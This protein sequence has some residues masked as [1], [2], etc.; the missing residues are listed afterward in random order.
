MRNGAVRDKYFSFLFIVVTCVCLCFALACTGAREDNHFYFV[1]IADTHFGDRDHLER[2]KKVVDQINNLPMK[3]QCVVHTGDITMDMIEDEALVTKGLAVLDDLNAPIHYVPGNHDI[4]PGRLE[5]TKQVYIE[6]LGELLSKKEYEGVIFIFIYTE[7][8]AESF[9]MDGYEPLNLLKA[10]LEDAGGN[11]VI[12]FHH[13]PSVEDFYG[14]VM[15]KGWGEEVRRPWEETLNSHNVKAVITGHFHRDEYHWLG[16]VPL[17]VSS[18]VAGYWGRQ[19]TFR[20]YEY[21]NGK[22]GYR[23]QYIE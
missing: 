16:G 2:T 22:V 9:M 10:A 14:N 17:Y 1:Q 12:V 8:L 21:K 13:T 19:A 3:I 23:T 5:Q 11:P 6:R 4:N 15:H 20:I 7:P 18:P